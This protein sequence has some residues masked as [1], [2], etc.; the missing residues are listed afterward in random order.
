MKHYKDLP[1][2]L[3]DNVCRNLSRAVT[4]FGLN[5]AKFVNYLITFHHRHDSRAENRCN[6]IYSQLTR[7]NV[8]IAKINCTNTGNNKPQLGGHLTVKELEMVCKHC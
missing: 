8:R 1:L 2:W 6:E 7:H 4:L 3:Q 5:K